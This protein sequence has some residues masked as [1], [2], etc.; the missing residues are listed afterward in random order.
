MDTEASNSSG[1]SGHETDMGAC[2]LLLAGQAGTFLNE[3]VIYP[4]GGEALIIS[5]I[6]RTYFDDRYI[7]QHFGHSGKFGVYRI[8][9]PRARPKKFQAYFGQFTSIHTHGGNI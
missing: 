4:D 8:H 3:Q 7:R 6:E 5:E 1:R 2:I 9:R